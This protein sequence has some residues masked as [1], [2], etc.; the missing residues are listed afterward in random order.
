M[1]K[2]DG[3]ILGIG[4]IGSQTARI[5]SIF[6]KAGWKAYITGDYIGKYPRAMIDKFMG[7]VV[8]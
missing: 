7:A 8:S 2:E 1:Y 6:E 3:T 4:A 5:E